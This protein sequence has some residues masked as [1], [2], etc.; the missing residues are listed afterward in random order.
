[1][2]MP[3]LLRFA[4]A[5]FAALISLHL[6]ACTTVTIRNATVK[7][8]VHFGVL[9]LRIEFDRKQPSLVTT[10]SLGLTIGAR[11]TTLGL[12]S[13]SVIVSADSDICSALI[14]VSNNVDDRELR[15]L[16]SS[17]PQLQQICLVT[18]EDL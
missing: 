15:Q 3:V 10:R 9:V 13:E 6:S 7:E 1:M 17:Q 16:L 12:L 4:L 14:I 11:S 5:S 8:S 18:E 2:P